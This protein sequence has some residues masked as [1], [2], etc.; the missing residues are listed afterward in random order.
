MLSG[1]DNM[2]IIPITH[3]N[4]IF[5]EKDQ[6]TLFGFYTLFLR[7]TLLRAFYVLSTVQSSFHA[8][9]CVILACFVLLLSPL[10]GKEIKSERG[11]VLSSTRKLVRKKRQNS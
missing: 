4:Y 7:D 11:C 5:W 10:A 2:H 1:T 9:A 3:G 8:L 6:I